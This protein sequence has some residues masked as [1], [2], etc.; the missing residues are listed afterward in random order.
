M[1]Q[2]YIQD[3]KQ[4]SS[5]SDIR[6]VSHVVKSQLLQQIVQKEGK[7]LQVKAFP[8]QN[9]VQDQQSAQ[10]AQELQQMM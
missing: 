4:L 5:V 3:G 8:A 7:A 2:I 1:E 6:A 9:Y 10:N